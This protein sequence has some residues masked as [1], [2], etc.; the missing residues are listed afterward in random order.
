MSIYSTSSQWERSNKLAGF[1]A[2]VSL[3]IP[4]I[5]KP[6]IS[7]AFVPGELTD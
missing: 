3:G 4:L 7:L 2:Q 6:L 1:L 5:G